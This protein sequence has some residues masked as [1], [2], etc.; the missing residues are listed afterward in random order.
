M[1]LFCVILREEEVFGSSIRIISSELSEKKRKV[2]PAVVI[3]SGEKDRS[4]PPVF[5]TSLRPEA[6]PVT[7]RVVLTDGLAVTAAGDVLDGGD[8]L[9]V[10]VEAL[11]HVT[12]S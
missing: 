2:F 1:K 4:Y 10:T 7:L 11:S 6:P 9:V 5:S 8:H 3:S 12:P